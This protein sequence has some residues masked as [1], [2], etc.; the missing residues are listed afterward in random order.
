MSGDVTLD[1]RIVQRSDR[2]SATIDEVTAIMDAEADVYLL[3]DAVGSV[4][5]SQIAQPARVGDICDRLLAEYQVDAATCERDV[6]AFSNDI[7]RR[8][9]AVFAP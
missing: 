7:V 9:L 8:G 4:I 1:S 5:W 6:L 2:V 3:I